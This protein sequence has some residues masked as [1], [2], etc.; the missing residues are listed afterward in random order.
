MGCAIVGV[1][2]ECDEVDSISRYNQQHPT[3]FIHNYQ[4]RLIVSTTHI[5][6]INHLWFVSTI[7]RS[8][9]FITQYLTIHIYLDINNLHIYTYMIHH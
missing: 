6:H 9:F 5:N 7:F 2:G 4:L 1:S 3:L 8:C